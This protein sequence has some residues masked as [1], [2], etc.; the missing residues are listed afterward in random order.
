MSF[1]KGKGFVHDAD[2]ISQIAADPE[3]ARE[4]LQELDGSFP[5]EGFTL[6]DNT[7]N[8]LPAGVYS[9]DS[10]GTIR[11]HDGT[12]TGGVPITPVRYTGSKII[13]LA[14][15]G[16]S[17]SGDFEL[18]DTMRA[19]FLGS[20]VNGDTIKVRGRTVFTVD[21]ASVPTAWPA[22][23]GISLFDAES[24]FTDDFWDFDDGNG[25]PVYQ[26]VRDWMIEIEFVSPGWHINS[27]KTVAVQQKAAAATGTP[28]MKVAGITTVTSSLPLPDVVDNILTI[29]LKLIVADGGTPITSGKVEVAWDLEIEVSHP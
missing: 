17:G 18:L 26:D 12:T 25:A 8:I 24:V 4:A 16:G 10:I 28:L 14:G 11:R 3:G 20:G 21:P 7:E 23:I 9:S 15:R 13:D 19:G 1:I 2:A 22:Y 29:P 27:S 5:V 6:A